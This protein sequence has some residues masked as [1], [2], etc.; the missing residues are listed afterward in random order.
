MTRR[1][2]VCGNWKLNHDLETTRS[3]IDALISQLPKNGVEVAIA[4]VTTTLSA[5][6]ERAQGSELGIAAQNV[7][8]AEKGA[9]T[10]EWSVA[11]LQEIG[12]QYA[13]VGHSERRQYFSDTNESVAKKTRAVFDGGLIPIACIGETL[14]EREAGN[15]L[16]VIQEQV[17]P[18]LEAIDA[19]QAQRLVL[20]YEPVWAIGTG[21]TATA[22]QAQQVHAYIRSL[23]REAF[24]DAADAL[25]IQYGGSVKPENANELMAEPDVDGALVGGASLKP[26]SFAAIVNA[27]GH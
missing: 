21:K 7:F 17:G 23:V 20:A 25:R 5:A 16:Q 14:E 15:T 11:H 18:I 12:C 8:W 26:E 19:S 27:S 13:I 22:A 2:F 3:V 1:A 9:Y 4:P 10:G 6:C 24:P